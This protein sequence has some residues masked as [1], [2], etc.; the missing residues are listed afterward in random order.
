MMPNEADPTYAAYKT[1]IAKELASLE[2]PI[3]LV[4]HSMGGTVLLRFLTEE[5]VK[6]TIAGIFLVAAPYWTAEEWFDEHKLHKNFASPSRKI[7]PIFFYHSRDD[8]VVPFIHLAMYAAELPQATIREFD[9]RG[10]QFENDLSEVAADILNLQVHNTLL[11]KA[12]AFPIA[13]L[14]TG[15]FTNEYNFGKFCCLWPRK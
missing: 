14:I 5:K 1:Q 7:P 4:G 10:H 9:G 13:E 2:G 3:V 11:I 12:S 15:R 6:K 8:L